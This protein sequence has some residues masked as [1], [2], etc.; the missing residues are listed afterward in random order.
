MA[1]SSLATSQYLTDK[2]W[3]ERKTADVKYIIPHHMAGKM[4]GAGCAYYF[5]N[6]GIENSANYCIGYDGSIS[7]DVDEKYGAWTSSFKLADYYAITIEVSDESNTSWVIPQK[8]QDALVEL[9]VDLYTRYPSLGGKMIYDESDASIVAKAKASYSAISGVKGN[10]LLHQW[11]SNYG[12]S[13]PE[14][15]M[16]QILPTIAEKVNA[17]LSGGTTKKT[18]KELAQ[19]V[20]D[21]KWGN[22]QTRIDKLTAAGY[23]ATEVQAKVDLMLAKSGIATA[24]FLKYMAKDNLLPTCEKGTK[25]YMAFVLQHWLQTAGYYEGDLDGEVGDLTEAAIIAFQKNLQTVYGGYTADGKMVYK[26]WKRLLG[27]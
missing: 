15:H 23:D 6:N 26:H 11:T 3:T 19:E 27:V 8:A 25:S 18:V 22:G 1:I 2:H 4:T 9:L 12:T 14:W 17:R 16:K 21:G 24:S 5:Q 13:C 20:I 7:C 10:V